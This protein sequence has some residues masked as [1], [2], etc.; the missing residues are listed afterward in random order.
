[1]PNLYLE[2]VVKSAK[3]P[4]KKTDHAACY[5]VRANVDRRKIKYYRATNMP[6]N[7]LCYGT[8]QLYPLER[9]LIPTGWKMCCDPGW[10][11]EVAPRSGTSL[12]LGVSLV[13]SIGIID[14]DY[15]DEAMLLVINLGT[16]IIN[17]NEGDRIAQL[18]VEKVNDVNVIVG[19]L[20]ATDSN[21][22]G[23]LGHTGSK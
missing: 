8:Y 9:A 5:D 3:I 19:P 7:H 2:C 20:P 15:R 18:S 23:G 16:Q 11:I 1:M 22:D 12:K 13:N 21:R 6:Q 14:A 10:K 17:I 4:E